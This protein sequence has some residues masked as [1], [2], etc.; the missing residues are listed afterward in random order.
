M[1]YP[2]VG[3]IAPIETVFQKTDA[4]INDFSTHYVGYSGMEAMKG[5][6]VGGGL[7]SIFT[8][9]TATM[10]TGAM[11]PIIVGASL[12]AV[13]MDKEKNERV[14]R[15][16]KEM[17]LQEALKR[18]NIVLEFLKEKAKISAEENQQL[19]H[20]IYQLIEIIKKLEADL[21]EAKQ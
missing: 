14:T 5:V 2:T 21:A 15:Q 4:T 3:T 13:F 7:F 9:V 16:E 11:L 8:A 6:V 19:E 20:T 18:Q 17:L 10:I 12:F 1:N